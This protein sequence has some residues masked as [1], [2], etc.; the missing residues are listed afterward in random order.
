MTETELARLTSE[1][2]PRPDDEPEGAP[3]PVLAPFIGRSVV[4]D[5]QDCCTNAKVS[6]VL[7]D[8]EVAGWPPVRFTFAFGF[9]EA[10]SWDIEVST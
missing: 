5:A 6:G 3:I 1:D 10:E 7:V 4:V 2:I 8:A 9:V